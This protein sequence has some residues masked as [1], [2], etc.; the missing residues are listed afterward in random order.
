M[1]KIPQIRK[2]SVEQLINDVQ[3][4]IDVRIK[5]EQ[6]SHAYYSIDIAYQTDT[7]WQ[8]AQPKTDNIRSLERIIDNIIQ[9]TSPD[10]ICV[11]VYQSINKL[12]TT[13]VVKLTDE[14]TV[15]VVD[16]ENPE[17]ETVKP[18]EQIIEQNPYGS[19]GAIGNL[20]LDNQKISYESKLNNLLI[21][22]RNELAMRQMKYDRQTESLER[23][24]EE[25]EKE[26]EDL[27]AEND[28]L[29]TATENLSGIVEEKNSEF[30]KMKSQLM[31]AGG[32]GI[33]GKILK[34]DLNGLAGQINGSDPQPQQQD[35]QIQNNN[36]SSLSIEEVGDPNSRAGQI[37][38]IAQYLRGLDNKN[39]LMMNSI[40][41]AFY[42][43]NG[44]IA[45]V[46]EILITDP[47]SK[48]DETV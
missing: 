27:E 37:Q 47:N 1:A 5:D 20:M 30:E 36:E 39:M 15:P 16:G 33:L 19:L 42:Q 41:K 13:F 22:H 40:L 14:Y 28:E 3:S 12:F 44:L 23:R 21:E 32:L 35:N 9:T 29:S 48:E 18:K 11:S 10:A 34:I 2:L 43:D 25:L 24:I 6:N 38:I 26:N 31:T 46:Y 45:T 7:S 17:K 4:T 8:P